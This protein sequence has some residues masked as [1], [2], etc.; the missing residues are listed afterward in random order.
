[1]QLVTV[2][3][4][5]SMHLSFFNLWSSHYIQPKVLILLARL[6]LLLSNALPN[7]LESKYQKN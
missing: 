3:Q 1:M 7:P 2:V 5:T 6:Q 4:V